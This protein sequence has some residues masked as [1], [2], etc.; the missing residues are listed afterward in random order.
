MNYSK[1]KQFQSFTEISERDILKFLSSDIEG[2]KMSSI[3]DHHFDTKRN[4]ILRRSKFIK[5]LRI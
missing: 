4:R 5:G 2:R 3:I 1:M